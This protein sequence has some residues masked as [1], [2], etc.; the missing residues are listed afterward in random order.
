MNPLPGQDRRTFLKGA[1]IVGAA[2]LAG[3]LLATASAEAALQLT[4]ILAALL[5]T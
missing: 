3:P 5:S 2:S 1:G 4:P